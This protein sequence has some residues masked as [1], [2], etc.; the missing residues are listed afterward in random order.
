[1]LVNGSEEKHVSFVSYSGDYPN[2]CTGLL[3]LL[4]DGVEYKFNPY[5]VKPTGGYYPSFWSSGG[6]LDGDYCP[7][8]APWNIDVSD[9]PEEIRKYALEIDEIFNANVPHG[10]CGGCA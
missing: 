9:L 3:V 1:M 7:Y 4:V 6:G 2:L 8:Q 10:C 5:I